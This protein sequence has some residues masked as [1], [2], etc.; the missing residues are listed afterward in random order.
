MKIYN[1]IQDKKYIVIRK[2]K[3]KKIGNPANRVYVFLIVI[4]CAMFFY[5]SFS[6][7]LSLILNNLLGKTSTSLL[8]S[9]IFSLISLTSIIL[10]SQKFKVPYRKI[11][12]ESITLYEEYL[13][14]KYETTKDI[15]VYKIFYDDITIFHLFD[16]EEILISANKI[17]IMCKNKKTLS[18]TE[19]VLVKD[20]N[21]I[22]QHKILFNFENGD[23]MFENV[24]NEIEKCKEKYKNMH[25]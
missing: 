14:H 6:M 20:K 2:L 23:E 17:K 5:S 15:F 4:F 16:R 7:I 13:E 3:R 25:K 18:N 21:G 24:Q 10:C 22:K 9:L 1:A 12:K 11:K 8:S 19:K